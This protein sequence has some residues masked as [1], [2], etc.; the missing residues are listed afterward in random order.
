MINTIQDK[1]NKL[2]DLEDSYQYYETNLDNIY[3]WA[4]EQYNTDKPTSKQLESICEY[5]QNYSDY[6]KLTGR[7][8][9]KIRELLEE[10]P[11]VEYTGACY[12]L[13]K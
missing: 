3:Y 8:G 12:R 11:K 13:E 10:L 1:L 6:S 7:I 9:C 5:E 4:C 2:N